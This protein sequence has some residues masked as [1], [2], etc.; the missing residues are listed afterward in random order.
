[1]SQEFVT[2]LTILL[3][4]VLL[5]LTLA[6]CAVADPFTDRKHRNTLLM[7]CTLVL[8]L[9]AQDYLSYLLE[10]GVVNPF[11]R[12]V[13]SIVGYT[14]RP[15]ILALFCLLVHPGGHFR[16]VWGLIGLNAAVYL[17]AL[18]SPLT[19][20]ISESNR[21]HGGPLRH[22]CLVVS[23]LL[24]L[25][26]LFLTAREFH[27]QG[28]HIIY[29]PFLTALMIAMGILLDYHVG[30]KV[31]ILSFLTVTIVLGSN[32]FYIWLHLRFAWLHEKELKDGQRFQIMLSQ[33]RPHF[34]INSLEAI[35][36]LC[37]REPKKAET[38]IL[39]FER[40]LRGNMDS[41][42]QEGLIPFQTELEHTRFYLELEQLRFPDELRIEYDLACTDFRVPLLTLQPLAENAVRHGVRG[43][44]SGEGTVTIMTREYPDRYELSVADDGPGFDPKVLPEDGRPHVGLANVRDRL[45]YAGAELRITGGAMGGTAATITIPKDRTTGGADPC[46][47]LP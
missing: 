25:Y 11:A 46:S 7:I 17:T 5:T 29:I 19:F 31:Q 22:F 34:F 15:V 47:Y 8:C 37:T 10:T 32:A 6:G 39:T 9:I 24:L 44:K 21:F 3:P 12:T 28:R 2:S 45:H 42:T 38:A 43:K 14:V 13:V 23:V 41:L 4:C 26:L 27:S 1:M 40:Y 35:R 20:S 16:P 18:F 36:R 30:K 33:I